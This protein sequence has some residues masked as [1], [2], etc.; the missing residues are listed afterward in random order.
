MAEWHFTSHAGKELHMDARAIWTKVFACGIA[1]FIAYSTISGCVIR[2]DPL[3]EGETT[4]DGTDMSTAPQNP[5]DPQ[6]SPEEEAE[7]AFAGID[8]HELALASAKASLTTA[9]LV[10]HVESSGGDPSTLDE[11]AIEQLMQEGMPAA[12]AWADAWLA[13]LDSATLP[14]WHLNPDCVAEHGCASGVPCEYNPPPVSHRC[15]VTDCG[16]SKCSLCPQWI[17]D[18][19]KSLAISSWCGYVCTEVNKPA[20]NNVVAIGAGG[21][22]K[23]KGNFVGP[24]CVAPW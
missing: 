8:P 10:A 7:A 4:G 15:Y 12:S 13:T 11:A 6:P 1:L 17:A 19:L 24:L 16:Q 2:I 21:I 3:P 9:Y 23:L 22:S 5:V 18:L 20:P 14:Q